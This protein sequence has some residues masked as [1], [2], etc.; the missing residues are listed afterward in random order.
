[1]KRNKIAILMLFA[2]VAGIVSLVALPAVS[3]AKTELYDNQSEF[4]GPSPKTG[5]C[6]T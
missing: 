3:L 2:A 4:D 1:M 6:G 5:E